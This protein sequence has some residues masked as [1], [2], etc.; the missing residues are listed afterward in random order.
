MKKILKIFM[1]MG[2]VASTQT[3]YDS[4]NRIIGHVR[5]D[6][7]CNKTVYDEN[8]RIKSHIRDTNTGTVIYN[9]NWKR[10]GTIKEK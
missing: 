2:C 10:E 5:T 1:V 7:N 8:W 4:G 6:T 9:Q 3:I